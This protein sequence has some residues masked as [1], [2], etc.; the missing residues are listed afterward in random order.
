MSRNTG[1]EPGGRVRELCRVRRRAE[2]LCSVAGSGPAPAYNKFRGLN[3]LVQQGE[4][5]I[6]LQ[7]I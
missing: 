5:F 1:L 2:W 4:R 6:S 3:Q 7:G